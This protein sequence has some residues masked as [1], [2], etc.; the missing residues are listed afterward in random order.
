MSTLSIFDAARETPDGIAFV[1][2]GRAV[3]FLEAATRCEP[4][5]KALA[6]RRLPA[7]ALAP[8]AD[9]ASLL[10]I[11]AAL[12]TGTPLLTLHPRSAPSERAQAMELVEAAPPPEPSVSKSVSLPLQEPPSASALAFIPTSGS[13]G[14]PRLV[15][16][17]RAAVTA[18]ASASAQ[19]LGWL[20]DD[21][22]LLCLPLAHTG[23]LSIVT[24]CLLAR[25]RVLLFEP[26]EG[27]LLSQVDEL[28]HALQSASLASLVPSV[29]GALLDRGFSTP[30]GLRAVLL[31]GAAC[32]P[33]LARRCHQAGLPLLTSYGLTETSSQVVTRRYGE[34]F[35]PLPERGGAVS[36]GHPLP[37]VSV[38][39]N[40]ELIELE[41]PTLF[42]R[43]V[44]RSGAPNPV[45]TPRGVTAGGFWATSDRGELGDRGELYVR[46]RNDDVIIT[47]GENVDPVEVEAALLGLPGVRAACVFG[48]PSST[49]GEVVT[50][51][52][53]VTTTS[54]QSL[55]EP[56]HLAEL[57]CDR[58]ARQKLPRRV[59]LADTLPLTKSGKV[60]RR[61]CRD[62]YLRARPDEESA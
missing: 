54:H 5:A 62:L 30:P 34:R 23:G 9:E 55:G 26:S 48:T 20:P 24:R 21:S 51:V 14:T 2:A 45:N 38:R 7:L 10:W 50:A 17:S 42:T 4:L 33:S 41:T 61:A 43:Y 53:A 60:D 6:L 29:L 28:S 35:E 1:D 47:G 59:L 32:A 12:A 13:T 56:R 16:L 49:F 46:G 11:Y 52:I 27:G 37:G 58:L 19:N 44:E 8:R 22:W 15:E 39:L 3:S 36:S 31:G 18:S 40:G 57:L 25:R